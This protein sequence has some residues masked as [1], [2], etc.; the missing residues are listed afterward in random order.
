MQL[1]RHYYLVA[2]LAYSGDGDGTYTYHAEFEHGVKAWGLG[3]IVKITLGRRACLGVIIATKTKPEFA[4]RQVTA[5]LDIAPL[6]AYLVQLADWMSAYYG[7]SPASVWTT[8]LPAGLERKR[9]VKVA[10]AKLAL[11]SQIDLPL[12]PAQAGVVTGISASPMTSQ[13]LHGITGSGK[14]RVYLELALRAIAAGQSVI[15]LV[16]EITLAPQ[17]VAQFE[18]TFGDIVITTHSRMTE[19]QRHQA[20]ASAAT[21]NGPRIVVGPRSSLFLPLSCLGLIVIDECHESTY[22]QDQNP[23]YMATLVAAKLA[24]IVGAKLVLGSATPGLVELHMA[25]SGRLGYHR[26]TARAGGQPLPSTTII[27]LRD[28]ANLRSGRLLSE[29]LI[30]ALAATLA[31]GRQSLLYLNRRGSASSQLCSDCGHVMMCPS[32]ELPLTFHADLLKLVCH[33][34]NYR[35]TPPAICPNCGLPALRYIGGG[36]K[37]I[38]AEAASLFP[39]ARIARLDRD[40]ADLAHIEAVHQGLHDGTID[41]LIGTQMIAKGLDI[42]AIDTVGVVSADT[43]LHLPDYRAAERTF[44]LIAQVSG[45]AGR[46]QHPGQV[47]VQTY[48]PA[49]PAIA[50]ASRHDYDQFVASEL[51]SRQEHVYPPYTYLVKL[52][53]SGRSAEGARKL[54]QDLA[55]SLRPL[56]GLSVLGPAPAFREKVGDDYRW[57]LLVKSLSRPRLVALAAGLPRA[58]WSVDLDPL[59][60]L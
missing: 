30:A 53:G 49:H 51:L 23:R 5:A 25:R 44:D 15:I 32:C 20:W 57:Q 19:S 41:I 2:P 58:H 40:S 4:T 22:K 52:I 46:G 45:R 17:L 35:Q 38:E 55:D 39:A 18:A 36:T 54:C 14:T 11:P 47:F 34:C 3:Q 60:T 37:R 50:A 24:G 48:T 9:R 12:T 27:D 31:E 33:H 59:D 42:P 28:K 6:P 56:P 29:P 8:I 16:P 21:A 43:M 7:A 1:E 10:R 26:L 13:L